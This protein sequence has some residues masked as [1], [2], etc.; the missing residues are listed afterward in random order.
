MLLEKSQPPLLESMLLRPSTFFDLRPH[1]KKQQKQVPPLAF[2][3]LLLIPMRGSLARGRTQQ[4][5]TN[6]LRTA[7]FFPILLV[8]IGLAWITYS[9]FLLDQITVENRANRTR[10]QR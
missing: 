5:K 7:L 1:R 4:P 3:A 6:N 2:F 9:V 8:P 10:G